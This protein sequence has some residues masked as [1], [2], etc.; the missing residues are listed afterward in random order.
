LLGQGKLCVSYSGQSGVTAQ[1]FRLVPAALAL[2][3]AV[4]GSTASHLGGTIV[5]LDFYRPAFHLTLA[6]PRNS[7]SS[8]AINY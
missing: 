6:L 8:C 2:A 3:D 7:S 5:I 4:I 1:R